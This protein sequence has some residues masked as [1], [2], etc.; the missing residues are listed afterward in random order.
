MKLLMYPGATAFTPP[1]RVARPLDTNQLVNSAFRRRIRAK[2]G[3]SG[4]RQYAYMPR[5]S[6]T[7]PLTLSGWLGGIERYLAARNEHSEYEFLDWI[8]SLREGPIVLEDLRVKVDRWLTWLDHRFD[9]QT[10]ND[11]LREVEG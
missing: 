11:R 4:C 2:P 6:T 7:S 3:L 10:V 8:E 5:L 1:P 9:C